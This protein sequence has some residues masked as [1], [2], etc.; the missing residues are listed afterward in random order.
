LDC[1]TDFVPEKELR[2]V[3]EISGLNEGL[4]EWELEDESEKKE[5]KV[6]D[7]DGWIDIV[8]DKELVA[9]NV[10]KADKVLE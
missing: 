7:F 3:I 6:V 4:D 2:S 9:V 10:F 1:E 8:A 5:E